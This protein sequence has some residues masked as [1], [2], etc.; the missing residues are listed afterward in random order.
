MRQG[1]QTIVFFLSLCALF[2]VSV[3]FVSGAHALGSRTEGG[4][5]MV[6][7]GKAD[8]GR[9]IEVKSG[10]TVG[11]ELSGSGGTGYW[12]YVTRIDTRYA[13][14]VSEETKQ[15][16]ERKPGGPVQGIWLIKAKEP[17]RTEVMLKYY[18]VWEGPDKAED[19]FSIILN[20]K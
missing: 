13:E 10:A 9:Q 11:I 14:V 15:V 1:F 19:Q 3:S 17:G 4:D 6:T 20:I 5:S 2:A 16:G 18:R 12:W 7:L 8:S